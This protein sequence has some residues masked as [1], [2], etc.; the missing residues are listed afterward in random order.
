MRKHENFEEKGNVF[1]F[2][3]IIP[4]VVILLGFLAF[5]F[6]T[7]DRNPVPLPDPAQP[8]ATDES[9]RIIAGPVSVTDGEED[10]TWVSNDP[11]SADTVYTPATVFVPAGNQPDWRERVRQF[12]FPSGAGRAALRRSVEKYA[13]SRENQCSGNIV[14]RTNDTPLNIRSGPA[15]SN[16]VV[17]KASKGTAYDVL[18]WANDERNSGSRWFLLVDSNRKV[19]RGWVSGEFCDTSGVSFAN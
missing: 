14:V 19:V 12:G 11:M 4:L 9:G 10:G 13:D 3:F 8:T 1:Q 15:V 16:P 7:K 18:M 6:L 5:N 2:K 17:A